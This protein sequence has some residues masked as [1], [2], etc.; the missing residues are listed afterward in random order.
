MSNAV[1]T[2]KKQLP[3]YF[4]PIIEFQNIMNAQGYTL[5]IL[6]GN[7]G[8]VRDNN[9][10]S[11]ADE[12][13]IAFWEGVLGLTYSYGDTL[14]YR[15]AKVL[16]EFTTM[17]PFSV[18][19]LRDRLTQLYGEDGY[20]L[21]VDPVECSVKIKVTSD[22]YGAIDLLY[23]LLWN[24]IPAHLQIYANQITTNYIGGAKLYAGGFITTTYIQ[25]IGGSDGQI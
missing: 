2:L 24:I 7:V 15:R 18:E 5:D 13:T 16:Q 12:P 22:R 23:T 9:Y 17:P 19:F 10:I 8:R 25:T 14:D 3:D 11:T 20:E 4:K 6:D 21:S 1:N